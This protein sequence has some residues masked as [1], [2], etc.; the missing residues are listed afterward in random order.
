MAN[1][2][3]EDP[4]GIVDKR[5]GRGTSGAH[6]LAESN[7]MDSVFELRARLAALNAGYYTSA[8]LDVMTKNDM[9]YALRVGS[10]DSA[11]IN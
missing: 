7:N 9:V 6:T 5:R 11:G 3:L 1:L 10:T 4:Y 2:D 8:R